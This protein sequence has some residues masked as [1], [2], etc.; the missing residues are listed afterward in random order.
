MLTCPR[1]H[2][3]VKPQN[4]LVVRDNGASIYECE[5]KLADLGLSHFRVGANTQD[6]DTRGTRVYGGSL[7]ISKEVFLTSH[8]CTRVLLP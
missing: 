2:Q 3:D 1:W 7:A 6:V 8:R 5:F 4:I